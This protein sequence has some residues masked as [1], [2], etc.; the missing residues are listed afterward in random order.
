MLMH[1]ANDVNCNEILP[2]KEDYKSKPQTQ[3]IGF[4]SR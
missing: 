1:C 2:E 4:Y 3:E